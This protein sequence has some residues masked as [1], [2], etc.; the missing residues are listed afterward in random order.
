MMLDWN[1]RYH[2]NVAQTEIIFRLQTLGL[3]AMVEEEKSNK[4]LNLFR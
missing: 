4:R 2:T 1:S 3:V